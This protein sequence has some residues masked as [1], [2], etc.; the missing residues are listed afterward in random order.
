MMSNI[1]CMSVFR[2]FAHIE[3]YKKKKN[4]LNKTIFYP[5]SV[6]PLH[7]TSVYGIRREFNT[8]SDVIWIDRVS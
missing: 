1:L 2:Q 7:L 4:V 3:I 5:W 8:D 6:L